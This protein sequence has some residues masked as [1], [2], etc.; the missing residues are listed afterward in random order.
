MDS[1]VQQ[2][3]EAYDM[4]PSEEDMRQ[5][6][7]ELAQKEKKKQRKKLQQLYVESQPQPAHAQRETLHLKVWEIFFHRTTTK[8]EYY[9]KAIRQ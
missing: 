4:L 6:G 7:A 3:E 1:T 5:W 9:R 8:N 2:V